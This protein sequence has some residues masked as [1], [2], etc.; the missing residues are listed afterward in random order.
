MLVANVAKKT[1]VPVKRDSEAK[2]KETEIVVEYV[3]KRKARC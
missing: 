1:R 2:S 3:M